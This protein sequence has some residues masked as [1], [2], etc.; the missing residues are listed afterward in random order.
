MADHWRRDRIALRAWRPSVVAFLRQCRTQ[1]RRRQTGRRPAKH[2]DC[3][4]AVREALGIRA[5]GADQLAEA[6]K[7]TR[8]VALV[9]QGSTTLDSTRL[10][11]YRATFSPATVLKIGQTTDEHAEPNLRE[12]RPGDTVKT[13]DVLAVFSSSDVALRK[14]EMVD[15]LVQLRIDHEILRLADRST[16]QVP[17]IYIENARR[18]VLADEIAIARARRQLEALLGITAAKDR[19]AADR[20]LTNEEKRARQ[21]GLDAE[22][23][24]VYKDAKMPGQRDPAGPFKLTHSDLRTLETIGLPERAAQKLADLENQEIKTREELAKKLAACLDKDDFKRWEGAI[25]RRAARSAMEEKWSNV[26]LEAAMDGIIV[27]RNVHVGETVTDNTINL[28]QVADVNRL[29]VLATV[30]EDDLPALNEFMQ[31]GTR[32]WK[33]ARGRGGETVT[34]QIAEIG[35]LIDPN[36]HSA[37]VKGWID[38]PKVFRAGQFVTATVELPPPDGVEVPMEAVVDDGLQ[39]IVIVQDPNTPDHFTMRRVQ[40]LQRYEKVVFVRSK[41]FTREESLTAREK[42][43]GALPREPLLPGDKVVKSG[44]GEL[45]AA[46]FILKAAMKK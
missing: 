34:G 9:L 28:F 46:G 2:T 21:T 37:V 27:E 40:V 25:A 42:E 1:N 3:S 29:L 17:E 33:V 44:A 31:K 12:L 19:I 6:A 24:E 38:R 7:R 11:R 5:D 43:L 18:Q 4:V 16:G 20:K 8:P 15:A 35:Y 30:H 39:S 23:D 32:T 26:V 41:P 36:E 10:T 14:S 45:K 13:G 22:I